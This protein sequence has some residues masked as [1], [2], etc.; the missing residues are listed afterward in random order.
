MLDLPLEPTDDLAHPVFKDKASCEAWLHQLQLTNLHQAHGVLRTQLD[1]FNRYPMR[2]L[3]RLH[4]LELLRETVVLVQGDYAKKL[5]S[6]K[7]PLS[8][9]ELTI[10]VSIIGLWEGLVTGYQ[11]CL[12]SYI[13]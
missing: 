4:T 8:D 9:D 10:F 11:S 7:L 2:G 6:K 3:E 1:E 12:Q 13:A 5:I